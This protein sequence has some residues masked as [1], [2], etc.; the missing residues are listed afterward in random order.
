MHRLVQPAVALVILVSTPRWA[1]ARALTAPRGD[2]TTMVVRR[3]YAWRVMPGS[4]HR[5][6]LHHVVTATLGR[7][8]MLASRHALRVPRGKAIMIRTLRLFANLVSRAR[9]LQLA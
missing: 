9:L 6:A 4:I 2:M 3:P 8:L 5:A 1:A 7:I